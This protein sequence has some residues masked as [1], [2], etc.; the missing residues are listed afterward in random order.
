MVTAYAA[1][2]VMNS[3][4]AVEAADPAIGERLKFLYGR[5]AFD[6]SA[7]VTRSKEKS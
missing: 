6:H 4:T 1:K 2:A 5:R 7:Q 3:I